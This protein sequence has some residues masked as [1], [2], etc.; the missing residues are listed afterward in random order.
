[1]AGNYQAVPHLVALRVDELS[2]RAPAI[3]GAKQLI[4]TLGAL[5]LYPI[6]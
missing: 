6:E 1:L 2:M 5:R 3:P 4:R